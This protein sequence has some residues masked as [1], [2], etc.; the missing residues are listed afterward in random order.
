MLPWKRHYE[1]GISKEMPFQNPK[2]AFLWR[3]SNDFVHNAKCY[4][5]SANQIRNNTGVCSIQID[6][7]LP[8]YTMPYIASGYSVFPVTFIVE[9]YGENLRGDKI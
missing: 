2:S 6:R 1:S 4:I 9:I 8:Q 7:T 3:A 5:A